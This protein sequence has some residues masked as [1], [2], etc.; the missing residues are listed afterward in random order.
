MAELANKMPMATHWRTSILGAF[1]MATAF[2]K[3][4]DWLAQ[5]NATLLENITHLEHELTRLLPDLVIHRPEAGYLGWL[6]ISALG[7]DANQII[8]KARVS[9]VPG[10][11]MGGSKYEKFARLNF[12]T[13]KEILTEGL[14][15]IANAR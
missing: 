14:T 2:S 8:D 3:C 4:D 5:T 10:P 9:L 12:G 1:T 6:E 15:R 11:D 13:S 7:M